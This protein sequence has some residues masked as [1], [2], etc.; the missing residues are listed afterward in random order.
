MATLWN[1]A[2]K[3][4]PLAFVRLAFP[5]KKPNTPLEHFEGPRKWQ[6]EVLVELREHIKSND[7]KIDFETLRLAVSS[8]RGI[9]K[10]ALV[11]WLTIWML[12]TRIG[13]TTIV[14]AN[15]EAQLRSVTWAEIT[16]WLSM[17]IHSHWFE[18]S[19][20][21][22]LPAKWI[23]ELVERDLKMGTRYWGVEGR[24][25][26]AENPDAYAG[27]HNFAGVMLVFDE[28][29]G[30]DDSI[31][32]VA[33]G[34][35]TENTPNR[36]W[37]C[38]SNPRRNSGYFYE[39]FNSKRDFWRNKIVDARSVEGTDK[40]VYQQI[41]DEYGPDSSAAH[42][43]V[44]GQFPNA[45]DDQFIGNALVD[46]AMERPLIADQSAPIVVGVDPARFGADA[47][48]IAIR[49]G[50]DILSIRRHRGDDTMEVVGRV[51]D[52]IEEYKPALV[53]IDEGG[54]G[55]G[56]VDRLKEQRYKVRGVNFGNKS[57]KPMMYGNKRA[58]MWG[59]MKEWLKDASIPK[60]RYLKSDLIG[61]MMKPDSK[62][63]IFLE[64]KKDMKSRGLA[65]PD[66][67]DAIAVTFAFPVARREQRVDNQRRVTYAGGGNSS[68]WMAH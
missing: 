65:S 43:E 50:R 60:D 57:S 14:S 23:A 6:R 37:L 4:D 12:T 52:V 11:S 24:L 48:V 15:S 39:C 13:S 62:G 66:A 54:L 42:V 40:A 61:P 63:T 16:K 35:F 30:I 32:S 45:S 55:A 21:R 56:V 5:W 38:F 29:S 3:N 19:A 47:T 31:W 27:V 36:F 18:V 28:A 26:S 64:S 59:A 34:F 20:T 68:G 10:S 46:E 53:V 44:Y 22:V 41:I 9:G 33:A 58:E 25:W 67:A 49:Q 2:L 51:I 1:P 17:S 8:G 7:G